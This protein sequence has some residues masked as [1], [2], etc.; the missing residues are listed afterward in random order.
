MGQ[1]APVRSQFVMTLHPSNTEILSPSSSELLNI[2]TRFA[3][4][5]GTMTNLTTLGDY[6]IQELCHASA[7]TQGMLFLLDLA[8][9]AH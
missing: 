3:A 7:A 1:R 6:I 4:D 8:F 9:H 2:V 5:L